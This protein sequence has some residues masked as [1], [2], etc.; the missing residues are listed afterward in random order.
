MKRMRKRN[1]KRKENMN[2]KKREENIGN[3]GETGRRKS[4]HKEERDRK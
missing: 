4:R 1:T 2:Q 3:K